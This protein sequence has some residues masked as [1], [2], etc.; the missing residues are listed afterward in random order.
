MSAPGR[1]NQV[2]ENSTPRFADAFR[3]WEWCAALLAIAILGVFLRVYPSGTFHH[4]G[5]DE[6]LYGEYVKMLS[7]HGVTDYPKIVD[8]Y[9]VEQ[10]KLPYSILPPTRFLFIYTSYVWSLCSGEDMRPLPPGQKPDKALPCLR[11]VARLFSVLTFLVS[12][13]F[14]FRLGGKT[15]ALAVAAFLACAPMQ[16]HMAQYAFVDGFFNF[17]ALLTIWLFWECLRNPREKGFLLLYGL[18]FACMV[19]TKENSFF[20]FVAIVGILCVNRPLALGTVTRPLVLA[21]FAGPLLGLAILILLA[22]GLGS[23]IE[24][25]HLSVT[26]NLVHPYAIMTGDGPWYRYIVELLLISPLILLL[27][28]GEIFRLNKSKKEELFL[29]S[30]IGFSYLIMANVRYGMNLRYTVMWDMPL[31]YL[32]WQHLVALSASWGRRRA[33]Y[34]VLCVVAVC[35]IELRQYEVIFVRFGMYEPVPEAVLRALNLVKS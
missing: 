17:W 22:G 1:G 10:R 3:N 2:T 8:T 33:L 20:V 14:A 11:H 18:S 4:L 34:L 30:F 7:K 35:A 19:M 23:F 9:I 26:K 5:F 15:A 32:A 28:A 31:R 16:I 27:A 21:T 24:T 6:G 25:Y 12:F 13:V 29:A